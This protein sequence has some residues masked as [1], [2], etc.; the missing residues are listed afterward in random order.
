MTSGIDTLM[1]QS[2]TYSDLATSAANVDTSDPQALAQSEADLAKSEEFF[3]FL[4]AYISDMKTM[5]MSIINK[6]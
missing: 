3:G 2:Q 6:M 4:S 1:G 5:A